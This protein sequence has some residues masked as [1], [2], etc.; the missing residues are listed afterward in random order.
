MLPQHDCACVVQAVHELHSNG[1]CHA[2]I[3][4]SNTLVAQRH[5]SIHITLV[6]LACSQQQLPGETASCTCTVSLQTLAHEQ[7]AVTIDPSAIGFAGS[8]NSCICTTNLQT[9]AHEQA[10]VT[11]DASA[12]G[13]WL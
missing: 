2:D 5:D 11:P 10:A 1:F 3:K 6:D 9:L 7:A 12:L 8:P 4:G 13:I